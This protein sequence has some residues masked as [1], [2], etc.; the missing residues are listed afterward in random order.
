MEQLTTYTVKSRS[1]PNLWQFKYHLNGVL[2]EFK[3]LDGI[4][5]EKQMVWLAT[6]FPF[7]ENFIREWQTKAKDNFEI[8]INLPELTFE[9]LW[10]L[11]DFKVSKTD[12]L[13]SFKKLNDG[14]ILRLFL[15]IP[16]YKTHLIQSKVSQAHLAT[17][18]NK[19]RF[20]DD[21]DS[22]LKKK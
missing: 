10:D 8:K 16:K 5:S 2:A 11:Y 15:A 18:I 19:R 1:A 12:A 21:W 6:H 17:F 9:V 3:V 7:Q 20:D 22:L 13:R 4:L 14:E